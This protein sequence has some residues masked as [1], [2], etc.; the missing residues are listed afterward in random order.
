MRRHSREWENRRTDEKAERFRHLD[1]RSTYRSL[2]AQ[3]GLGVT[4]TSAALLLSRRHPAF[5]NR[6]IS[7]DQLRFGGQVSAADTIP[8]AIRA[9]LWAARR[10]WYVHPLRVDDKRPL[11]DHWEERATTNPDAI[12]SW[13]RRTTGYGIACGPSRLVVIDGD[14]PKPNTPP[15]PA[16]GIRDGLDMLAYLAEQAKASIDWA[17]YQVTTGR[18][19]AHL[20]YQ[21]PE[22]IELRNTAY[23]PRRDPSTYLGWCIDTR[24]A[25]GYV[26]GPG[27]VVAGKRYATLHSE[28]PAA[29][30]EWIVTRLTSRFTP[31]PAS[32]GGGIPYIVPSPCRSSSSSSTVG[33]EW[34]EAAIHGELDKL[35]AHP[36]TQGGR[37]VLLNSVSYTV[38]RLVGA[39]VV[40]RLAVEQ[41]LLAETSRWWGTGG[42]TQAEAETTI[43]SGLTAGERKPRAL[44]PRE[45]R[46]HAA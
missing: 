23:D 22:D 27:S 21:A 24:S 28:A 39:G 16:P 12:R 31:V 30:S 38:G 40:E 45:E 3:R 15:P 36:G 26:V 25:G 37:N 7:P 9:A 43:R 1:P 33:R 10:G 6:R 17:T 20:Y 35:R 8:D 2:P 13:P 18:L 46:R 41:Q 4:N 11:W 19:G 42:F 29:L 5:R 34:V 44:H 14:V 32:Q